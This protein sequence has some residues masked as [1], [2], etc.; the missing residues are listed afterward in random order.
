M[1]ARTPRVGGGGGQTPGSQNIT[2]VGRQR[3]DR[4]E[5]FRTE[6]GFLPLRRTPN[7]RRALGK[8]EVEPGLEVCGE[9]VDPS[10][11][12]R[13]FLHV[14]GRT[15]NGR[16]T[17]NGGGGEDL[18]VMCGS[19]WGRKNVHLAREAGAS[20]I[21]IVSHGHLPDDHAFLSSWS[22]AFLVCVDIDTPQLPV[23]L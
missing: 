1:F 5:W 18:G 11:S 6:P 8:N 2:P 9:L 17:K 13:R 22:T 12:E 14:G 4:L 15:K 21:S 16:R 20:S 19:L 10:G 7:P 23:Y 3:I